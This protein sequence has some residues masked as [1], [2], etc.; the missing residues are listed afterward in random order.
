MTPEEKIASF[1]IEANAIGQEGCFKKIQSM[2]Q[3]KDPD[4]DLF[5]IAS[6]GVR[7]S[8]GPRPF[9]DCIADSFPVSIPDSGQEL[10]DIQ[11]SFTEKFW[12][13]RG[14]MPDPRDE[15]QMTAV[16]KDYALHLVAEVTE[17]VAE[18][19]WKMHRAGGSGFDR[20]NILEE[21][22][23]VSKFTLGL[24]QCWGF[25]YEE[26]A[27]E[28]RRKSAVVEQRFAQEKSLPQLV[29][30][31][32]CIIDI[33]GV[34]ADY[35]KFYYEWC[36]KNF[37]PEHSLQEFA[38]LYRDMPLLSRE[39]L[40]KKYRQSGA[41]RDVTLVPGAKELLDCVR[42]R[43]ALKIILM[44]NRPYAD[45]Y[46]IY[47]DTLEWLA[48]NELQFDGIIWSRDKGVDALKNFKNT[49]WAVDDNPENV[50]RL[51]EA[52]I[53]TAMIR[54]E[55][56]GASTMSLYKLVERIPRIEDVGYAWQ[57][58]QNGEEI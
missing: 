24:I 45:H 57:K 10:W 8:S 46:R 31:P 58:L 9:K 3:S 26:Y 36:I 50:R 42:R 54:N 32:C 14:G 17:V 5:K 56:E 28:F 6:F 29:N 34:L 27:E 4:V 2:R 48:K 11:K 20:S 51:R 49:M 18:L 41:K 15:K 16:T 30:H 38:L 12:S 40:K 19:S 1:S 13:T 23:D 53:T 35:P 43:S 7:Y 21:L 39:E 33:D 44:T 22:I 25:T 37:Y 47:P 52:K 55:F